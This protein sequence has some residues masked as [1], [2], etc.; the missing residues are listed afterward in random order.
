MPENEQ[1]ATDL[2][3]MYLGL[4]DT[5]RAFQQFGTALAQSP[6]YAP[7][8]LPLAYVMQV[9]RTKSNSLSLHCLNQHSMYAN[10][11]FVIYVCLKVQG[12]YDVA[13]S[14]YKIAAQSMPES[15]A[16]WNNIGM[17]LYGKQKYVSVSRSIPI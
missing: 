9:N 4:G 14:K 15:W 5:K 10:H 7:A 13:F 17:C 2:G 8:T 11:Q 1:I 3:L 12:E 6:N 16:L